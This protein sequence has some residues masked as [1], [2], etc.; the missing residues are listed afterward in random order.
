M[1]TYTQYVSTSEAQYRH[2]GTNWTVPFASFL[3]PWQP[4]NVNTVDLDTQICTYRAFTTSIH[5]EKY[6]QAKSS[7][8]RFSS[9]STIRAALRLSSSFSMSSSIGC[10]LSL[11]EPSRSDEKL[12]ENFVASIKCSRALAHSSSAARLGS[13]LVLNFRGCP[14]PKTCYGIVVSNPPSQ[15]ET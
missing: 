11:S 10:L 14:L 15:S 3:Y 13:E 7:C 6:A 2:C 8:F 4:V 1:K 9:S 5:I 12:S